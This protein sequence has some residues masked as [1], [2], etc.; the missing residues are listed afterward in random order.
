MAVTSSLSPREMSGT[1][2]SS[3]PAELTLWSFL[4]AATGSAMLGVLPPL[5]GGCL[6]YWDAGNWGLNRNAEPEGP[7]TG[8]ESRRT[9]LHL[10]GRS[11]ASTDPSWK[12]GE[13]PSWPSYAGRYAWA[14]GRERLD[15]T[16]CRRIAARIETCLKTRYAMTADQISPWAPCPGCAYPTPARGLA[17]NPCAECAEPPP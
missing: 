12:W 14:A 10:L 3:P 7:K 5:E 1:A 15:A 6:N 2:A 16:E 8:R 4:V 9:H 17:S 11:V 13:A